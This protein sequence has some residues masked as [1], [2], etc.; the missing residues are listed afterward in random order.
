MKKIIFTLTAVM[1]FITVNA[2][3]TVTEKWPNGTKKSEGVVIGDAKIESGDSKEAQSRKMANVTK[4][5]KWTTWFE[6]GSV[7]AE[8]F[9]NKGTMVGQ[10]K[11]MYENGQ[12]ESEINFTTGKAVYF[13]KSG[14]TNSEGG[15]ANGMV[16]TGKWIGYHENGKIN[17]E[18]SYNAEGQKVGVWYWYDANGVKTTEQTFNNGV[19]TNTRDLSKK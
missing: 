1:A 3:N 16:H 12:V 4:D 11:E 6:N 7:R 17:Y 18:G 10:W 13:F 2:Q 15:I 9:Y 8:Q 19:L 14:Q 5:G